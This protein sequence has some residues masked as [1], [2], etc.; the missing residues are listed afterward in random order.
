[1]TAP[2]RRAESVALLPG[3]ALAAKLGESLLGSLDL[4]AGLYP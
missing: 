1:M 2:L 3:A 4:H